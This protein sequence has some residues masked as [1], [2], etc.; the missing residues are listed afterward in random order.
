MDIHSLIFKG[1][2]GNTREIAKINNLN[3]TGQAKT[4]SEILSEVEK[5]IR[6]FCTERN[7]KI[8][9]IRIWN[10]DGIT[11]FD[12]GSHSEFFHLTPEIQIERKETMAHTEK[13]NLVPAIREIETQIRNLAA[14]FE[15]KVKPYRDSLNTLRMV[16]QA[17]EKC[18]GEGRILRNR[19]CAEDDRPDPNDPRD[20]ISCPVCH[21]TGRSTPSENNTNGGCTA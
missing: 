15:A 2:H 13:L 5:I 12:V 21:G 7:F 4:H 3:D 20:Y 16:N 17:C 11:I 1:D 19:A 18:C 10:R 14:E 9:Y 8:H 6:A